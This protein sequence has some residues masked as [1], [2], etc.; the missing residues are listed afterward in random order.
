MHMVVCCTQHT[1]DE[2]VLWLA[3][4]CRLLSK[5]LQQRRSSPSTSCPTHTPT[6]RSSGSL[7]V[8]EACMCLL[9][10]YT[11]CMLGSGNIP[12]IPCIQKALHGPPCSSITQKHA[13]LLGDVIRCKRYA[14]LELLV[15]RPA[16]ATGGEGGDV[17]LTAASPRPYTW[18]KERFSVVHTGS[19]LALAAG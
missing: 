8:V 18:H 3:V 4:A 2:R 17:C 7:Q 15:G 5:H 16:Y 9:P 11:A 13:K 14:H 6:T 19:R 1:I 10:T 12:G